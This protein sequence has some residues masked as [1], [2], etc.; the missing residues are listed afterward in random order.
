MGFSPY[1]N[2]SLLISDHRRESEGGF[3][4]CSCGKPSNVL[5]WTGTNI[6][7]CAVAAAAY[8]RGFGSAD[9]IVLVA[10]AIR[11]WLLKSDAIEYNQGGRE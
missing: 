8:E 7:R 3:L 6:R 4:F 11:G 5:R 9:E 1:S 2:G 10:E